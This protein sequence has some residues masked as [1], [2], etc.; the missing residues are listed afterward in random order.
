MRIFGCTTA[1]LIFK[2]LGIPIHYRKLLSKEWKPVE[3]HFEWKIARWICKMQSHGDCLVPINF[4]LTSLSMFVLSFFEIPKSVRKILDFFRSHFFWQSDNLKKKYRL[5][6]WNI[7]CCRPMDQGVLGIEVLEIKNKC[8]LNNWLFK[9]LNEQGVWQELLH[10]KYL[11]QTK[12]Y[13]KYKSNW[14]IHPLQLNHI[15]V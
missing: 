2:Y 15:L 11:C 12:L 6:K 14:L 9:L 1:N 7:I 3:D 10:S 4:V 13:P 5:R 8:L